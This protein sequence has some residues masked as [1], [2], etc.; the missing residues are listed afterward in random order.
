[1]GSRTSP[2]ANGG[3]SPAS[4]AAGYKVFFG[5]IN[6]QNDPDMR[7]IGTQFLRRCGLQPDAYTD[8]K[9]HLQGFVV[10]FRTKSDA[11]N[12]VDCCDEGTLG[13]AW[14]GS[15][16]ARLYQINEEADSV[17]SRMQRELWIFPDKSIGEEARMEDVLKIVEFWQK[18]GI[19]PRLDDKAKP[20]P[21]EED[22]FRRSLLD[23]PTLK[24]Q[25]VMPNYGFKTV[26]RTVSSEAAIAASVNPLP[27]ELSGVFDGRGFVITCSRPCEFRHRHDG[28]SVVLHLPTKWRT[29]FD[30]I[31]L[32]K[33]VE[34]LKVKSGFEG[35]KLQEKV[36]N[37]KMHQ[38]LGF[39][40]G[41][42]RERFIKAV[43]KHMPTYH[44]V[45][46]RAL[47]WS[48]SIL[49]DFI[50]VLS[51][52]DRA[53]LVDVVQGSPE[54]LQ[55]LQ[56][57]PVSRNGCGDGD[58][59]RINSSDELAEMSWWSCYLQVNACANQDILFTVERPNGGNMDRITVDFSVL[60][61]FTEGYHQA[62]LKRAETIRKFEPQLEDMIVRFKASGGMIMNEHLSFDSLGG[63]MFY[64]WFPKLEDAV[65]AYRM[66]T[67]KDAN[68]KA[69]FSVY[70]VIQQHEGEKVRTCA[71]LDT[72]FSVTFPKGEWEVK[73]DL[74]QIARKAE[75]R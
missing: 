70:D 17:V 73:M 34:E 43:E 53:D 41:K 33:W 67:P 68:T 15:V 20:T 56:E 5:I 9:A 12:A 48:D 46:V 31:E 65:A 49:Y 52:Q 28:E 22:A 55:K 36:K 13:D 29:S 61:V 24:N 37:P 30:E 18:A 75:A 4:S 63:I 1:M 59:A 10:T 58:S 35:E 3:R 21:E 66:I 64:L 72:G 50:G 38:F 27:D 2:T 69:R 25:N 16:T 6:K 19:C 57:R 40:D 39:R 23:I 51:E 62:A 44:G 26:V 71:S 54:M 11:L 47:R 74:K 7:R 42:E 60:L 8:L 32:P 45:P 14:K